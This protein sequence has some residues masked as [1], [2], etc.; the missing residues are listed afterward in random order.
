LDL[1][2]RKRALAAA[3]AETGRFADAIE[4]ATRGR[5]LAEREG[6]RS[7]AELSANVSRYQ[8]HLAQR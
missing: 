5:T 4:T 3:D 8:Q 7:L 2:R 6:N 1:F